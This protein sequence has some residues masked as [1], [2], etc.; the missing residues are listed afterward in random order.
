MISCRNEENEREELVMIQTFFFWK[1]VTLVEIC[2]LCKLTKQRWKSDWIW[3]VLVRWSSNFIK[4]IISGLCHSV[5]GV[6]ITLG[7]QMKLYTLVFLSQKVG[8]HVDSFLWDKGPDARRLSAKLCGFEA[9]SCIGGHPWWRGL[10]QKRLLGAV[11][12]RKT[13]GVPSKFYQYYS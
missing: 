7:T 9:T 1:K 5:D 4:A 10:N 13:C 3:K 6:P 8:T 11:I 2:V 12:Y